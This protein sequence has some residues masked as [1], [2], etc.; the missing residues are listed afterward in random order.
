MVISALKETVRVGDCRKFK[1]D[2]QEAFFFEKVTFEP[3]LNDKE[4]ALPK[5]ILERKIAVEKALIC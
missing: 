2:S 5:V 1:Y 4:A 3:E